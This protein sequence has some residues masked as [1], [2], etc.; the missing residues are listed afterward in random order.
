MNIKK[1]VQERDEALLSLDEKKIR[2]YGKK[3]GVPFPKDE[4][5]FWAGIHKART[6]ITS[7]PE[8]EKERSRKWLIEHG[9]L[10]YVG[11]AMP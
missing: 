10:P 2:A 1:F 6:A 11:E 5:V 3:Y 9:F 8:D 7:F 4:L